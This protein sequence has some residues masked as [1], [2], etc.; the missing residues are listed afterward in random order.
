M[1]TEASLIVP[2]LAE[3]REWLR[4]ADR[5]IAKQPVMQGFSLQNHADYETVGN[6]L[7][8]RQRHRRHACGRRGIC[9]N[10]PRPRRLAP[11]EL[12]GC[13]RQGRDVELVEAEGTKLLNNIRQAGSGRDFRLFTTRRLFRQQTVRPHRAIQAAHADANAL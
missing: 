2:E 9:V 3:K 12:V 7:R 5:F 4:P 6:L 1:R 10:L 13:A 11:H 8:E